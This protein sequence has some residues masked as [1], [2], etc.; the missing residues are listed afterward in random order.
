[1]PNSIYTPTPQNPSYQGQVPAGSVNST[2]TTGILPAG[3]LSSTTVSINPFNGLSAADLTLLSNHYLNNKPVCELKMANANV[4]LVFNA[5]D[6]QGDVKLEFAP[7]PDMTVSELMK[8]TM[9][10]TIANCGRL[11]STDALEYVRAH[12]LERHFKFKA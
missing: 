2:V 11:A 3:T 5:S 8:I 9:M 4:S 1:M 10:V 12:S 7:E 6:D